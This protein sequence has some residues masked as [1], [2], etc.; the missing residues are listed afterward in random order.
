MP[1]DSDFG[2]PLPAE[3]EIAL[4]SGAR[5]GL[6]EFGLE[7]DFELHECAGG[8]RFPKAQIHDRLIILIAVVRGREL[9]V[10][11]RVPLAD[12]LDLLNL[13]G[14]VKLVLPFRISSIAGAHELGITNKRC[15][16]LKG[17]LIEMERKVIEGLTGDVVIR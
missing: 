11:S 16:R 15:V 3:Q 14:A 10:G 7:V 9:Q 5:L 4:P 17:I 8:N 12:N 6:R 1:P 2:E 13:F